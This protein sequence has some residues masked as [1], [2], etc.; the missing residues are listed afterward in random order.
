MTILER[1]KHSGKTFC[2][3]S[4]YSRLSQSSFGGHKHCKHGFTKHNNMREMHDARL[5]FSL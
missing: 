2:K 5:M 1:R 4:S 3:H